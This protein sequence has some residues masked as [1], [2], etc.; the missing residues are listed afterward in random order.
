LFNNV[1]GQIAQRIGLPLTPQNLEILPTPRQINPETYKYYL[2]G[3]YNI[4]QDNPE[5]KK[6]GMEYLN[7]A[8][9]LDPADPFAYT[10]LAIGY[11]EIAQGPQD[12]GDALMK[13]EAAA[14]QAFKWILQPRPPC[15]GSTY[16]YS[17]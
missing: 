15:P 17:Y 10:A 12:T 1:A 14:L 13:G 2:R 5:A 9:K 11:F 8:V 16:A 7:E 3:M 4:S 6:K